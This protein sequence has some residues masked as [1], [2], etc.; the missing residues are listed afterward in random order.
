M[1]EVGEGEGS[2]RVNGLKVGRRVVGSGRIAGGTRENEK[3]RS[4][5]PVRREGKIQ[6]SQSASRSTNT[7]RKSLVPHPSSASTA[8]PLSSSSQPS[9]SSS[10]ISSEVREEKQGVREELMEIRKTIDE[11]AAMMLKGID[12]M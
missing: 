6:Q 1:R 10:S 9:A 2:G 8:L 11:V 3:S 7:D 4:V 12:V 5:S